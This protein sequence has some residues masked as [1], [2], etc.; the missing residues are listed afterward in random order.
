MCKNILL[1]SFYF[2]LLFFRETRS[3]KV[4]LGLLLL[5]MAL[6]A[7]TSL[8]HIYALNWL[9]R[10]FSV[11]LAVALLIIFQPEIRRVLAE[12]GRSGLIH[13]INGGVHLVGG[14]ALLPHMPILAQNIL[15]RPRV[16]LGRVVGVQGLSQ[17]IAN[18]LYTNAL[19][20]VKALH[21]DVCDAS[22]A[23]SSRGGGLFDKFKKWF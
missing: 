4:F 23:R 19:G 5:L 6:I 1:E 14:G 20:A 22:S 17:V 9:L 12:I 15:G 8:F 16:V 21:R 18:P 13:E 3:I 7:I 2:L 10:Q 11:Y